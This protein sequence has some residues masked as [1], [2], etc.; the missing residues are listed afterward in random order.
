MFGFAKF[1]SASRFC[2]A[3]DELQNYLRV[4]ATNGEHV[5]AD[6]RRNIFTDK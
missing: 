1:E 2:T 5:P 3:F 4:R 6:V